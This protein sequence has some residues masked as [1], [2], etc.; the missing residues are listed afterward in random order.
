MI[1]EDATGDL[2]AM[3]DPSATS[4]TLPS[5]WSFVRTLGA[6]TT[7]SSGNI[8]QF[9][10]W[11]D[12]FELLVPELEANGSAN[13]SVATARTLTGMPHGVKMVAR[14]FIQGSSA[15][16][17]GG[18]VNCW[19]AD[20]GVSVTTTA[21]KYAAVARAPGLQLA[22]ADITCMTSA[23]GQVNTSDTGSGTTPTLLLH[24]KGWF[25]PRVRRHA[26]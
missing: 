23:S 2:D 22:G 26:I 15:D 24:T 25:D 19:D 14:L 8:R 5:G 17:A 20:L 10:Q 13:G 11:G 12:Y 4:L 16:L 18:Y 7:N 6:V 3:F 21:G 1:S 9:V